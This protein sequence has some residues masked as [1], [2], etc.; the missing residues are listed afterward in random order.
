MVHFLTTDSSLELVAPSCLIIVGRK[1][2][3]FLPAYPKWE[4]L[5]NKYISVLLQIIVSKQYTIT[6]IE[7]T[8]VHVW[9]CFDCA[10]A[11]E[12]IKLSNC[13]ITLPIKFTSGDE[14]CRI[15]SNQELA[16][17]MISSLT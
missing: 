3:S 13:G 5:A 15:L 14:I 17:T 1:G 8:I 4:Q 2:V 16:K 9:T 11:R 12:L 10:N 6:N 7:Q